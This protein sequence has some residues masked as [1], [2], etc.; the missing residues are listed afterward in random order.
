VSISSEG[1]EADLSYRTRLLDAAWGGVPSVSVGGGAL[2]RELEEALAGRRVERSA[3]ALGR[4][5]LEALSPGRRVEQGLA[6]RRFASRRSWP[7]VAEP[8]VTWARRPLVDAGRLAF[9]SEPEAPLWRRLGRRVL[10]R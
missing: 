8:L 3:D 4:A 6:A 2:A 1:L 9:P 10:F 5:V 7:R